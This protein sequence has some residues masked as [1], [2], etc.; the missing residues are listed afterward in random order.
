M[1]PKI[2]NISL[3]VQHLAAVVQLRTKFVAFCDSCRQKKKKEKKEMHI[4]VCE[5]FIDLDL[6]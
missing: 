2:T 3:A 5:H 4:K 1:N 6:D